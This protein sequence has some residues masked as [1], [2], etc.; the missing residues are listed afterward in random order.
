MLRLQIGTD[1]PRIVMVDDETWTTNLVKVDFADVIAFTSKLIGTAPYQTQYPGGNR[2]ITDA[3]IVYPSASG[4]TYEQPAIAGFSFPAG[5]SATARSS[6]FEKLET[7]ASSTYGSGG[8]STAYWKLRIY[9]FNLRFSDSPAFA[10][11]SG[12]CQAIGHTQTVQF[13]IT[14]NITSFEDTGP[15]GDYACSAF[16]GTATNSYVD[17]TTSGVITI[18]ET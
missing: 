5:T 15:Y 1:E 13:T 7:V 6:T 14:R 16:S 12:T 4:V 17:T 11:W 10:K 9:N 18:S 2:F 3:P 8:T